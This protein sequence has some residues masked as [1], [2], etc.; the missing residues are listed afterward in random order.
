M[1]STGY[2]ITGMPTDAD[3]ATCNVSF[4]LACLFQ[5]IPRNGT[6]SYPSTSTKA[7]NGP[8]K[9]TST[10]EEERKSGTNVWTVFS[11]CKTENV[12][13]FFKSGESGGVRWEC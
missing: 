12:K 1:K 11:N 5:A 3:D 6:P 13:H 2:C 9:R 7:E 4:L 8:N 10:T